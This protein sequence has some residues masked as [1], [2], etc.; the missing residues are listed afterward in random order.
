MLA[1]RDLAR[2]IARVTVALILGL[3]IGASVHFAPFIARDMI[4]QK[5]RD[6][7]KARGF[8]LVIGATYLDPMSRVVLDDITL[9]DRTRRDLPPLARIERVRVRYQVNG[10]TNPRVFV[11]DVLVE[12]VTAHLYRDTDGRTNVDGALE[13]LAT[14]DTRSGGTSGGGLR[15]YL[16]N[17]LPSVRIKRM[18]VAVDDQRGPAL[19]TPSGLDLRH[20]RFSDATLEI[21]DESPVR[22]VAQLRLVGRTHIEG[23]T[24]GLEVHGELSWPTRE[25]WLKM[26][27]PEALEVEAGG[28]RL[29]LKRVEINSDGRV[30]VGGLRAERLA[31]AKGNP[32]AL[33]VREIEIKLTERAAAAS[34]LPE[35][36]R[37]RLPGPLLTV[38]RHV[39]EVA[40]HEPVLAG[41]RPIAVGDADEGGE[42]EV[43]AKRFSRRKMR[44]LLP[45]ATRRVDAEAV[46]SG[47]KKKKS[48]R[49]SSKPSKKTA[50]SRDGSKVRDALAGLFSAAADRLERNLLGLREYIAAQPVRLVTVHHGRAHYRDERLDSASSGEVSD[51]NAR[52]ERSAKDGMVSINLDFDVPGRKADNRISGRVDPKTGDTQ[53]RLHLDRLPL[54]PYAAFSP[55]SLTIHGDSTIEDTRL[56]LRYDAAGR[57]IGLDGKVTIRRV[58][59][60]APRISRHLIADLSATF[61][62]R[63]QLDLA[64]ERLT[65]EEG[66]LAIGKVR[67][68]ADGAISNYRK[69]PLFDLHIKVPTVDC[70]DT[71]DALVDAFAPMLSG[72]RCSGTLSFRVE[73]NLDTAD[74]GSLKFEFDPMLRNI[75]ILSLG[76]YINFDVLHMP[77][78]HHARQADETLYTF[79]TGPGSERWVDL[80]DIAENLTKV[81]NTTEDGTFWVHNGFSL[82]QICRAMVANLKRGRFV[83]G[84]STIS[85]QAVKNL[86]FVEREKTLSRKVQEAVITWEMERTLEKEQILGLYFNIIE[87]GPRIY[88][89]RAAANH[90]FNRQPKDLTLLQTLWLG[91]IIPGPRRW[92]HHFTE[93]KVS[94]GRQRHLCWL[95]GAM[96]KREKITQ[97]ERNRLANCKVV[98]G[99]GNDGSEAPAL[100]DPVGG[101]GHEGAWPNE[102]GTLPA[103]N[104]ANLPLP[105][106]D[107]A[108]APPKLDAPS[109]DPEDQP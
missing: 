60:D 87:F 93:G 90:Y 20:L 96:L 35:S 43:G 46:E 51:F 64:R 5:L 1:G 53:F 10:I 4:A 31:S 91:S 105:G 6:T 77:F 103:P 76:R 101:L 63:L 34:V 27:I 8:E 55:A 23:L 37:K 29:G 56:H 73:L 50:E 62:G 85:Q 36:L 79:I 14:R 94:E 13:W 12:G 54:A 18:R 104:G 72:M 3:A 57:K 86:F 19:K 15:K 82:N 49:K 65:F 100:V 88:G 61:Q 66:E 33:Q 17:H 95:G 75:K 45:R 30:I 102:P 2:M 44:K 16:S 42:T 38:L 98:F 107:G 11:Q 83:R 9:H 70:Q 81:V 74:M 52:I 78:E 40:V 97:A 108:P 22:E 7:A 25:G 32:L 58:D 67:I 26:A 89:I 59:V 28:F 24:E 106:P 80:P 84:A 69:A 71:A 41:R 99:G 21:V 109:V 39:E 68:R 47:K 92:Y 48:G